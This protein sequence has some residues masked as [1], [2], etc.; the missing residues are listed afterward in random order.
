MGMEKLK[1]G[2]GEK[3]L[4]SM[5]AYERSKKNIRFIEEGRRTGWSKRKYLMK[6]APERA[7]M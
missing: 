1:K 2:E 4:E 3:Y 6:N 7:K 5:T